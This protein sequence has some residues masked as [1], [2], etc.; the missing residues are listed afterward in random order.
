MEAIRFKTHIKKD[1]TIRVPESIILPDAE[2]EVIILIE[3]VPSSKA[4]EGTR[5]ERWI[6]QRPLAGGTI[7]PWKRDEIY[8]R[9]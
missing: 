5:W 6:K 9:S 8:G 4:E 2:A 1:H 3:K 7:P